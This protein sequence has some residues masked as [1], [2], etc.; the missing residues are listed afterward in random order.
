MLYDLTKPY[1]MLFCITFHFMNSRLFSIGKYYKNSTYFDENCKPYQITDTIRRTFYANKNLL[2]FFHKALV[3]KILSD[4]T[5][6]NSHNSSPLRS[7]KPF[8]I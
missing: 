2:P 5:F 6:V 3:F 4:V 8:Y 7:C 1:A